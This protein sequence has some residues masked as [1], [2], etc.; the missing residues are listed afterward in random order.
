[1]T[2]T[3][4]STSEFLDKASDDVDLVGTP[5]DKVA[6]PPYEDID[7]EADRMA[8][9]LGEDRQRRL[10]PGV[11]AALSRTGAGL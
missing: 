7:S 11:L 1:L 8:L 2:S 4:P 5:T 10:H 9:A 3:A 6:F